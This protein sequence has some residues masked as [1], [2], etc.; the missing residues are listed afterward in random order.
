VTASEVATMEFARRH[1]SLPVPV[2]YHGAPREPQLLWV[3]NLSS[4][5]RHLASKCPRCGHS[6]PRSTGYF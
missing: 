6:Y 5:R 4:W 2:Y 1:L 3:R